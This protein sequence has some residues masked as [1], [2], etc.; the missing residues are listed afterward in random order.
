MIE[1]MITSKAVIAKI[2][3]DLNLDENDIKITDMMS[4]IGEAVSKIGSVN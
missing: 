2:I 1:K 3:A 4:W